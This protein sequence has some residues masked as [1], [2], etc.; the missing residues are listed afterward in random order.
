MNKKIALVLVVAFLVTGVAFAQDGDGL[1]F[2]GTLKSGLEWEIGQNH[3]GGSI[4]MHNDD[5]GDVGLLFN[6]D[7]KYDAGTWGVNFGIQDKFLN[8][9]DDDPTVGAFADGNYTNTLGLREAFAWAGFIDNKINVKAGLIDSAVWNTK[10]IEDESLSN[11]L[12]VRLE[13]N[14]IEGL[15][16]GAMFSANKGDDRAGKGLLIG[17]SSIDFLLGFKVGASYIHESFY[18]SG[19]FTFYGYGFEVGAGFTGVENL[20]VS[21][22]AIFDGGATSGAEINQNAEYNIDEKIMVGVELKELLSGGYGGE[23]HYGEAFAFTAKPK[24]AIGLTDTI[25]FTAALPMVFTPHFDLAVQP[26]IKWAFNDNAAFVIFDKVAIFE[27]SALDVLNT[28]QVD[29]VFSF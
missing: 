29:F 16:F 20:L 22:E 9:V 13:F 12:G 17:T 10:G 7:G 14:L 21:V 26:G 28:V 2:S 8:G 6:L 3:T 24:A 15:S 27:K 18:V 1:S 25:I 5:E 11:G 19:A 23:D 4:R